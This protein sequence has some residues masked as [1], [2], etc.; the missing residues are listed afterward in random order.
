MKKIV[1]LIFSLELGGSE[2]LLVDIAN[3]QAQLADVTIIV[4]NRKYNTALM[5]KIDRKV[6]FYTLNRE[7]GNRRSVMFLFRLWALLLRI[8]PTVIHC[9]HHS[10]IRLLAWFKKRTVLTVH[11]LSI[12]TDHLIKYKHVYA[13]SGAVAGDIRQRA[14][15]HPTVVLNGINFPQVIHKYNYTIGRH[16]TVRIVQVGRL[17][18]DI[19]GQDLLLQALQQVLAD[20]EYGNLSVDFIGAGSS[21]GYLEELTDKLSLKEHV[22]FL[23]ERSRSWIYRQLATYDL[24]VQPSRSEGFGLTILEGIAAGL[25]VIAS[26]HAGPREILQDMPGSCLFRPGDVEE[27]AHCIRK[28]V[29][30]IRENQVQSFCDASRTLAD[31]Q[32]SI[33]NTAQEYLRH[34]ATDL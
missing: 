25:P 19:K 4:I 17:V 20:G 9:H 22:F 10:I 15:I 2:N 11:C 27:L 31:R 26:D 5:S 7:E 21:R 1:H 29:G 3:E 33:R 8:Q 23:G 28:Q 12:A 32:Y 18:H 14:G 34:Y 16:M 6:H 24:L 13:I 30:R